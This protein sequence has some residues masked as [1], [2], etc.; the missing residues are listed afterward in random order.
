MGRLLF[1]AHRIPFPPQKGEKIRAFHMLAHLSRRHEVELGC[2]VDDPADMAHVEALREWCS[3][4]EAHPIPRGP[5]AALRA[6]PRFRPGE[7]LSLAWFRHPSLS[8]WVEEGL[9]S[10]RW[11]RALVYSSAV[12][13][14]LMTPAA[15]Q[16]QMRRVLDFVD[17]DSAKWRAYA[18]ETSGPM[19]WVY[20]REA[21]T[22]LRFERRA[23]LAFDCS[24]FVS[25]EEA[26]CFAALAPET[27]SRLD[28]VDN[29][30]ELARFDPE[31][32]HPDPY[33][34]GPPVL[35]FTGT[36]DYRPNVDAVTWFAEEALPLLPGLRF[37]IV[38]ANPA[39][40]VRALERIP[41]VIVT[42]SVPDI[43]PYIAHAAAA[44]APL[45]IARGIQNK[46]LEAMAMAKP[47]ICTPQAFEGVRA[48]AGRDALI[49]PDAAGLAAA[50]RAVLDGH[51]PTLGEAAR[52]AVLAA[53][54][55]KAT[56]RRLDA[57]METR[58]PPLGLAA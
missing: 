8:A 13:P 49:A 35:V 9:E 41:G 37:A 46:V 50:V 40:T 17:V 18:A 20:A 28:H 52:A 53:H 57:V 4:V 23:A 2:L 31:I 10:R 21:E 43:R 5:A 39:P 48:V 56:L 33:P 22:L 44:V 34:A 24:I 55:W 32:E 30:V 15:Q 47:I 27:A 29:G 42:G 54:D 11:S 3:H 19:R 6:V 12:A 7:P 38:G 25:E 58:G 26:R 45:R 16:A 51:H 1:L 36:M 14:L